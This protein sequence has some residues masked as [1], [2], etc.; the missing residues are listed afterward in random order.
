[1]V[2][3]EGKR[4][5]RAAL[6]GEKGRPA[7]L[8]WDLKNYGSIGGKD[9]SLVEVKLIT[10]VKHQIRAQFAEM[11]MPIIGDVR[12]GGLASPH[13]TEAIGLYAKSIT[14]AHPTTH[15]IMTFEGV[16]G[17]RWPWWDQYVVD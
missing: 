4:I 13:W 2:R 17:K 3:D 14:L 1:M 6:P 15:E 12:Y 11:D 16:R 9:A 5:T 7:M 8:E 10:G